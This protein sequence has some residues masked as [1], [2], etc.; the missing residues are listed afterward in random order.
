MFLGKNNRRALA[1]ALAL[2][3]ASAISAKADTIFQS[4]TFTGNDTGEYIVQDGRFIGAAFTLTQTTQITAIGA[5]FGGF[6]GGSI[7]GAIV[8]TGPSL[9][10]FTPSDIASNSLAHVVF[11]VTVTTPALDNPHVNV[12]DLTVPLD[13]SLNLEPGTYAVVFGSGAFGATGFAGLGFEN[14]P[15]GSPPLFQTLFD[16]NW[17]SF[18]DH[19]VRIFVDGSAVTAVPEPGT[20]AMVILGFC[21]LGLLTYRRSNPATMN[22]A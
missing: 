22:I 14:D 11:S 10:S 15:V 17:Q 19:G 21:G 3:G 9:P 2:L 4:A 12:A 1:V 5:Q 18:G 13:Q 6:P 8:P 7:F 20:W 16:D